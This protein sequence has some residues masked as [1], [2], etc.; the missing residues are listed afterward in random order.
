MPSFFYP[1]N[2]IGPAV[3]P[4]ER[5]QNVKY[6]D[7]EIH[8]IVTYLFSKSTRRQW[9]APTA[10]GDAARGKELVESIGCMGCHIAQASI[11]EE[12]G[13]VRVA[14]RDD[15]CSERHFGFNSPVSARR[16][17][18]LDFQLIKN[19]VYGSQ[20]AHAEPSSVGSGGRGHHRVP[21]LAA[22]A[23]LHE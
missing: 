6:Q 17:T 21:D 10:A 22:E 8:S 2:M 13:A 20:R 19:P 12:S 23:A 5:A 18:E 7:A 14:R 15:S 4:A 11:K 1:R 3:P 16:R 9:P